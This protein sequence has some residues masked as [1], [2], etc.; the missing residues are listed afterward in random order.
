MDFPLPMDTGS[1]VAQS[2]PLKGLPIT[3]AIDPQGRLV[4]AAEGEREWDDPKSLD[5]VLWLKQ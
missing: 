3:Y 2:Y 1:K 5:Q 4:Y